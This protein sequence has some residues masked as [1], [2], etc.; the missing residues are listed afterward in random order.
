MALT[1]I[2]LDQAKRDLLRMTDENISK[3]DRDRYQDFLTEWLID[4]AKDLIACADVA[5][6]ANIT[7]PGTPNE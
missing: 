3:R 6:E 1:R 2:E 7:I 5:L 4:N